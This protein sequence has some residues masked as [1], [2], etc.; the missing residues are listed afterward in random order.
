MA[1]ALWYSAPGLADI[2]QEAL[3]PPAADEVRVRALFGAVSRGTEALVLAGRVP[4]S[5]FERMRAP[6][7]AGNFPFPVKYGYATVGRDRGRRR[8]LARAHGLHA[9]PAPEFLQHSGER[10]RGAAGESAAATRG[11]GRQHGD[12]AQRGLGRGAGPG[13]PH[14]RRRGRRGRLSGRLFVRAVSRR[15]GHARRHQPGARGIGA[16]PLGLALQGRNRQRATAT[17]WFTPA[18]IRP[19]LARHSR[20]PARRQPC[21]K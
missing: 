3:A 18:A 2:R 10:R 4:V 14:R 16:K 7:M 21:L 12:R 9:P 6:F 1:E 13:R 15:G 5:E 19:G 20:S 11:A 8:S 17:S